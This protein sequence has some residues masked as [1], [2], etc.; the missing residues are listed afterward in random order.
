MCECIVEVD[1]NGYLA[2]RYVKDFNKH[3]E[4]LVEKLALLYNETVFD[5]KVSYRLSIDLSQEQYIE[6]KL[7]LEVVPP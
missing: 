5:K 6:L 2:Y 7:L 1:G 3:R 4:E